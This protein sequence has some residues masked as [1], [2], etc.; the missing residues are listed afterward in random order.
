MR[1]KD[2]YNY[3]PST[4]I[5]D[6]NDYK[7]GEVLAITRSNTES[8]GSEKNIQ[9]ILEDL[10]VRKQVEASTYRKCSESFDPKLNHKIE[11]EDPK[12]ADQQ[13]FRSNKNV[14]FSEI[15]EL[16]S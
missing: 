7:F 10:R 15:N 14:R 1:N 16:I 13:L 8:N 5:R 6:F 2:K 9:Q 11:Y 4:D 3:K 12:S